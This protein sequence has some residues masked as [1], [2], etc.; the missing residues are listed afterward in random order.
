M[1]HIYKLN[2]VTS[3]NIKTLTLNQDHKC[4][5]S[6][7]LWNRTSGFSYLGVKNI[8]YGQCTGRLVKN[9]FNILKW[10]EPLINSNSSNDNIPSLPTLY[11]EYISTANKGLVLHGPRLSKQGAL[12][13]CKDGRIHNV[14]NINTSSNNTISTD[15]DDIPQNSNSYWLNLNWA[16]S[17]YLKNKFNK[18]EQIEND[19]ILARDNRYKDYYSIYAMVDL[20]VLV[21]FRGEMAVGSFLNVPVLFQPGI[22]NYNRYDFVLN[23]KKI[24]VKT[25]EYDTLTKYP[26]VF[27]KMTKNNNYK[28]HNESYSSN[29]S[30]PSYLSH[31]SLDADIYVF[32][33]ASKDWNNKEVKIL[34]CMTRE[35][36]Q[37]EF[38]DLQPYHLIPLKSKHQLNENS[39]FP[40]SYGYEIPL[41]AL[42]PVDKY[43]S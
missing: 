3:H 16:N 5:I 41:C 26:A 30:I 15:N 18:L 36:I 37:R 20:S 7:L 2:R 24:E 25:I 19:S 33:A 4:L 6:S 42:H 10:K 31:L 21:G 39:F 13:V 43:L 35:E 27:L 11:S 29:N 12:I 34:G 17:Y 38:S 22:N 14:N 1:S 23:K 28:N 40:N 32:C 8:L 9:N